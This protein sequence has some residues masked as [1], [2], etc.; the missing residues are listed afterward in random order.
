MA[1]RF[2]SSETIDGNVKIADEKILA[3]RT[4]SNDYAIQYRDL[5]FRFI[6]SADS[7]TQRKFSFGY[8]TSDNP[9][10]TWNGQ[11][12]INSYTGSVGIGTTS[13]AYP[14]EVQSGGVGTVLRAGTSFVSIDSTGSA[15][16]PSLI[17]NG[18]ANTG[19]WRPAADTLAV[20]TAGS[21]R[22][23]ITSAGYVGIGTITPSVLLELQDSTHTTMKIKS[24]NN[25]NIL[26]AQAIQSDEAR[27]GTDTN[28]P[29]SFFTNTSR[30]MTITTSGN[31]GIGT[32]LPDMKLDVAGNIRARVAGNVAGGFYIGEGDTSEAFGLLSQGAN[33]YFKI[34]DEANSADRFYIS[35]TGN[36][37]IATTSPAQ[38]LSVHGN[39][40]V[41]TTNADGNKNRM[42]C[43]VGGSSDAANL[44]L[45]YGNS[46]DGTVSVRLNAQG[47]SYLNGGNVGI[48]TTSPNSYSNQ[49]TLTI[50]GSSYGRLDLESGGTLRS[51]LFSQAANTTL[52]VST[53]FFTIDVGS[54]ILR[55]DTS[56]NVGIGTTTP[57]TT[58][59]V[60]G[61]GEGVY[62][63]RITASPHLRLQQFNGTVA[64]PTATAN[65]ER[66]GQVSFEPRVSGGSFLEM[67]GIF[68]VVNGTVSS[69][70]APTDLVFAAGSSGAISSNENNICRGI[71][72]NR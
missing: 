21:E 38:P 56:G 10:G 23:R 43:I 11:V 41:R 35:H 20:S 59:D 71:T 33:G 15:S 58:L 68:G 14:L 2:L 17:L 65:G 5:D 16:A 19:I 48:G 7:S 42:Q 67:C 1:V 60:R 26:F 49:T 9:A 70:A 54:E 47:D 52:A 62:I 39:L 32:T 61:S 37:G 72:S 6:G 4:S 25:D 44:Y 53:G 3:L 13:P 69:S 18:D 34:R 30:R 28:T 46:G 64:S 27:I 12:Y 31:V 51:S 22:M 8:Y 57:G 29:M 45:Y 40:L 36:V 66:V 24:G 63:G 50:N 55:I